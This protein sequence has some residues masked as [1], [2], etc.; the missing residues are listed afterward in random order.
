MFARAFSFWQRLVGTSP[1]ASHG[2]SAVEDDRR[3][4]VRHATDLQG[5]VRSAGING[6]RLLAS[7]RDLSCG[8]A[9]LLMAH[10]FE[11]GEMLTLEVPSEQ[12][13]T[14]TILACVVRVVAE[15]DQWSLGC[16]FARELSAD[17]LDAF[18]AQK[19]PASNGW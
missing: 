12:G 7:V 9:N 3:L 5:K 15:D 8:G 4:W 6:E 14:R 1:A 10:P 2:D 13:E 16:V 18:G 11:A 17:E 19:I